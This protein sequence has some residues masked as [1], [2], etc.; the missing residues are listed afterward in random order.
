MREPCTEWE[1]LSQPY[2]IETLVVRG[3]MTEARANKWDLRE[4][5]KRRMHRA[6][7][8]ALV[9]QNVD[10][11]EANRLAMQSEIYVAVAGGLA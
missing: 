11:R 8:N 2:G 4:L 5:L 10:K 3:N 7:R 6:L 1:A 9:Q